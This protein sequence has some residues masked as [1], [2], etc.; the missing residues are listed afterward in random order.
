MNDLLVMSEDLDPAEIQAKVLAK[1]VATKDIRIPRTVIPSQSESGGSG[2]SPQE[3]NWWQLPR[4]NFMEFYQG[5]RERNWTNK[6]YNKN[7]D[8]W[9]MQ[10]FKDAGRMLRPSFPGYRVL[11]TRSS[12]K[13]SNNSSH[14]D[15]TQF[16]V[17][18]PRSGVDNFLSDYASGGSKGGSLWK[19]KRE[20]P[21]LGLADY[22]YNQVLEQIF[23]AQEE[24]LTEV[25]KKNFFDKGQWPGKEG[26]KGTATMNP[27][28]AVGLTSKMDV[29]FYWTKP[30]PIIFPPAHFVAPYA[31]F[32]AA[33]F[34]IVVITAGI[35][36]GQNKKA[37]PTDIQEAMEF[38]QSKENARKEGTTGVTFADVGGLG[39]A[40]YDL[41]E[42]VAFMKNPQQYAATSARPPKGVLLSGDPGTGKTLIAKAIAGEAGVPFYQYTG[43]E[44]VE[45]IV[46][47][48]AARIRDMFR[49]ARGQAPCIVFVDEIDALG[50]RRAGAGALTNEEREQT[51]NQLLSEMDGFDAKL[52]I[53]FIAA[54]N[55]SDLLDP[56]LLRAGRFDR[57]VNISRPDEE[58]RL[59]VLKIH[60]RRHPLAD[61]VNLTQLAKDLPGMSGAE[62][63]N[64]LSE[65]AI[66]SIRRDKDILYQIDIFN[67]VD[68]VLQGI[69]APSLPNRYKMKRAIAVHE[70][71]IALMAS[72]LYRATGRIEPVERVT[73]IPRG[74]DMSRTFYARGTDEEYLLVTKGRLMDR[75]KVVL[76]GRAAEDIAFNYCPTTL[77]S[78]NDLQV[79]MRLAM[80]IVANYGMSELGLM[81]YA[82][83]P[84]Q[85]KR[86]K[87]GRNFEIGADSIDKDLFG[88]MVTGTHFQPSDEQ[89]HK[90]RVKCCQLINETYNE[91]L[92]NIAA[93][94]MALTAVTDALM[95]KQQIT[96]E[97]LYKLV[98]AHPADDSARSGVQL[99]PEIPDALSLER[100]TT[101]DNWMHTILTEPS[102]LVTVSAAIERRREVVGFVGGSGKGKGDGGGR[103]DGGEKESA[104]VVG[105]SDDGRR[106][107]GGRASF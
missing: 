52:G 31:G 73:I 29:G 5:L 82:P 60:A 77:S 7:A 101:A 64:V 9:E 48:G 15:G 11:V 51:L 14:L 35:I 72:I 36:K 70:A 32:A 107:G 40:I 44:F 90:I 86:G 89:W 42:I 76:S 66:S 69:K 4:M 22:G 98:E 25:G 71:G 74:S 37:M 47:V 16:W 54:T 6:Y 87:Q 57:K 85:V 46:G 97:E 28:A 93:H 8:K 96:G 20:S 92:K 45:G 27:A 84:T 26:F 95:D 100:R 63:A 104:R 103:E 65:A 23:Q 105:G 49:R 13:G 78:K 81:P 106:G 79:A 62:L 12:S 56:A 67:A 75:L 88:S 61:D 33:L 39:K 91:C 19:G 50:I 34:P 18:L 2:P 102:S 24:Q 58:G 30:D 55:R 21:E 53:L 59:E 17:D 80:R 83:P 68:R 38:A 41:N 1:G 3:P 94:S 10:F 43:S 99:V